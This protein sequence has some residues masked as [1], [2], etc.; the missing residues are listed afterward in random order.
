MQMSTK[1]LSTRFRIATSL[2]AV[3]LSWF[4]AVTIFAEATTPRT[5]GLTEALAPHSQTS[6]AWLLDWPAAPPLRGD[7]LS[8]I[9][10]A[11]AAPILELGRVA[12]PSEMRQAQQHALILAKRSVSLAPHS[13]RTWLLIA[14]LQVMRSADEAGVEALKMSYL[15]SPAAADVIPARL[16]IFSA[17]AA[18][19]DAE[20]KDLA[21][22][23]IRLILTRRSDMKD[24]IVRAY[25]RGSP[26]GKAYIEE[27]VRPLDPEFAA[28]LQ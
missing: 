12:M 23:D 21:R 22:G 25:R 19:A 10:L 9:A 26:Q 11:F 17:S 1:H 24:A 8:N 20:L 28:S 5:R 15:T 27:A 18:I 16:S 3:I 7:L 2:A 13:S 6:D 4:S 14:A